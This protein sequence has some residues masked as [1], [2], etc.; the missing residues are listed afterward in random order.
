MN[1]S[2][3]WFEWDQNWSAKSHELGQ[4]VSD[5]VLSELEDVGQQLALAFDNDGTMLAVGGEV[6]LLVTFSFMKM[7][8]LITKKIFCN[9]KEIGAVRKH[10]N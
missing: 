4:K 7:V 9:M 8:L 5:K 3:R 1:C 2:C 6:K 10:L